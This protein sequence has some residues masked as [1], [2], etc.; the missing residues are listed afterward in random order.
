MQNPRHVIRESIISG[1]LLKLLKKAGEF[2][3]HF[4]PYLAL[5]VKAG[6]R[7][8]IDL[9]ANSTGMEEVIAIIETNNCFSDGIQFVTGCTFGN[10]ALIYRDYGKTAV[11][12]AQRSSGAGIRVSVKADNHF[13]EEREPEAM[14]LFQTVVVNRKGTE[15]D[16]AKLMEL[17][18]QASFNMLDIPDSE[19]FEVKKV[20]VEIPGY[21]RI[22]DS[23][24]CSICGEN[25]ME[26]RVKVKDGRHVCIPCSGQEYY[27]LA[28]DGI[29]LRRHED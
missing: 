21:A 24:K 12:L 28:G 13:L 2:H 20:T 25:I 10:N 4:C 14:R 17:W 16:R 5:G 26:P 22:F 3:G 8:V 11:T 27:Q 1:N 7:A 9:G 15:D 6:C 19:L 29:C 23:V 18:G